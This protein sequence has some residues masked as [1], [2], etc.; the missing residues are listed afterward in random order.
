[1]KKAFIIGLI[2]VVSGVLFVGSV[3]AA[4]RVRGYTR[5]STGT[6]VQSHYKSPR[7]SSRFNNYSTKGNYNP[8][9][10]KKGYV[11]PYKFNTRTYR[12]K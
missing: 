12:Y 6:Y 11:N 7:D 9:T 3:D 8:Y 5:K 2:V 10:G 1:M 4:S